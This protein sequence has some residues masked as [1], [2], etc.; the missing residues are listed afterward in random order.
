MPRKNYND[1]YYL[2]QI[3]EIVE[4]IRGTVKTVKGIQDVKIVIRVVNNLMVYVFIKKEAVDTCESDMILPNEAGWTYTEEPAL[5]EQKEPR[6]WLEERVAEA[7]C[8][9]KVA[10]E[11]PDLNLKWL[12]FIRLP[13][14]S[15]Y[16]MK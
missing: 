14:N 3:P 12:V 7:R 1:V 8:K 6:L 16:L 5:N 15:I 13:D 9:Q 11:R 10:Q 4:F 2:R